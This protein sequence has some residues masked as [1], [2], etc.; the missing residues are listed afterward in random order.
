VFEEFNR[1]MPLPVLLL[2]WKE[3][4]VFAN[5]EAYR[6]CAFWNFGPRQAKAYNYRDA[7]RVPGTILEAIR[8]TKEDIM[9]IEPKNLDRFLF[10]KSIVQHP[11]QSRM[12][13]VITVASANR[14]LARP[15]FF[16]LFEEAQGSRSKT[17][18]QTFDNLPEMRRLTPSEREVTRLI[19]EGHSNREIAEALNK[20]VLTVKTQINAIFRKLDV[21][22]RTRLVAKLK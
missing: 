22:S 20:S 16:I 13:A 17:E 7:F 3:S 19:C 8:K 12:K 10:P 18:S 5:Q 1:T 15:G 4:L 9:A 11:S 14:S 6:A 21:S 2:D